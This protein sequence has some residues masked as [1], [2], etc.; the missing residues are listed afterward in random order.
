VRENHVREK[1]VRRGAPHEEGPKTNSKF[2]LNQL[3]VNKSYLDLL[4]G[5]TWEEGFTWEEG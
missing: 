4:H 5:L 1:L 3:R 2:L